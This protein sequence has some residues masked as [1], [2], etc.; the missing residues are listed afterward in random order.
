ML[1]YRPQDKMKVMVLI[2][3]VIAVLL[4]FIFGVLPM[5]AKMRQD[6]SPSTT[7]VEP[8]TS[9]QTSTAPEPSAPLPQSPPPLMAAVDIP[10][11]ITNDP[12]KPPNA[13]PAIGME[14]VTAAG[15]S[16][17]P[18]A[19]VGPAPIGGLQPS[20]L[21]NKS[22]GGVVIG[23]ATA[24]AVPDITLQGVVL[25][26]HA[27]GVFRTGDQTFYKHIGDVVVGNIVLKL[28]S[29]NGVV[30]ERGKQL[31]TLEIGH[32]DLSPTSKLAP[33]V[34]PTMTKSAAMIDKA[35]LAYHTPEPSAAPHVEVHARQPLKLQSAS[36]EAA[37]PTLTNGVQAAGVVAADTH[38]SKPLVQAATNRILVSPAN[39]V[40]DPGQVTSVPA[41][42]LSPEFHQASMI[43]HKRTRVRHK[44]RHVR[45]THAAHKHAARRTRR[46][47]PRSHARSFMAQAAE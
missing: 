1:V 12:F 34:F 8:T 5:M 13:A 11:D 6:A 7:P 23:P 41:D 4:Y 38:T 32:S 31:F 33:P 36:T 21:A 40:S 35:A 42:G 37:A 22:T 39:L 10:A 18:V 2:P 20:A 47:R 28:V 46:A 24:P 14:A 45:R 15:P 9:S 19:N 26:E 3:S 16:K 44:K 30:L 25:A 17:Q 43:V 29:D 27:V